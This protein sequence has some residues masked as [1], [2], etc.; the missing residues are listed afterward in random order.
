MTITGREFDGIYDIDYPGTVYDSSN[1]EW[2]EELG[3]YFYPYASFNAV[4]YINQALET[5][6]NNN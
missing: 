1:R 6:N 3:K 2:D 4:T 5:I